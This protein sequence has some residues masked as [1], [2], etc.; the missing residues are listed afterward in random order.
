MIVLLYPDVSVRLEAL[1]AFR[2][3]CVCE[4]WFFPFVRCVL[5]I[6]CGCVIAG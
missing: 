5:V 4:S 3:A 2:C 1:F 6:L